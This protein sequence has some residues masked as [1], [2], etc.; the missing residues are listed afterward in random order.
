M[1]RVVLITIII[2]VF[3]TVVAPILLTQYCSVSLARFGK[4]HEIGDTIG[5]ITSPIIGILSAV[6]LFLTF[7]QQS[8]KKDKEIDDIR[9]AIKSDLELIHSLLYSLE[10]ELGK[11]PNK[12][13]YNNEIDIKI[14]YTLNS[15]L[16]NSL[17]RLK[18]ITAFGVEKY[19][20]LHTIYLT[21]THFENNTLKHF[22]DR[23]GMAK[24]NEDVFRELKNGLNTIIGSISLRKL[25]EDNFID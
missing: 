9:N 5:G 4:P 1:T 22:V 21:L 8:D 2:G 7:K 13:N 3:I 23:I 20:I 17:D 24:E 18:I 12:E 6:L 14:Y 10:S 15:N 16:F 25:I 19:K 11:L